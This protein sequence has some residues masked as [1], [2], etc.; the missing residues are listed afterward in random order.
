[1]WALSK[2]GEAGD[3]H[4][5]IENLRCIV[6]DAFHKRRVRYTTVKK[7]NEREFLI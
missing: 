4:C 7:H 5:P 1:M 3:P 2:P 6:S